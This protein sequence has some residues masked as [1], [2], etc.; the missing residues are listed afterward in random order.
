MRGDSVG[1]KR[2]PV[3]SVVLGEAEKRYVM[4]CLDTS[5]I[6][7]SGKYLS[8][9]QTRFAEFC[10]VR[11]AIGVANGT[12]AL[13]AALLAC[14]VGPGDEVIVPTLTYIATANA[15]RHCGA[16]PIFVD[17][18]PRTLNM[19][20][21]RIAERVT[22]RTKGI[23]AVHLYGHPAD[24]DAINAIA[25]SFG[26]FVIED[27]AEA[28]GALYKGRKVGSLSEMATFSFYGNKIVTTGEGGMIVSND[29]E[30][31]ARAR[32]YQGQGVDPRR[33]YW[34]LV[35]GYNFRMTNIQAAIGLG[36]MER[37][38]Q[39]RESR[40]LLAKWYRHHLAALAGSVTLLSTEAWATPAFWMQTVLLEGVSEAER[41]AVILTLDQLGVEARPTFYP[42]HMLPPYPNE[43]ASLYPVANEYYGRGISLPTHTLLDESDVRRICQA[44]AQALDVVTGSSLA[45]GL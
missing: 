7:S 42:I 6:S 45:M 15:V 26:L 1:M 5:W 38:D 16:T 9:F 8:D 25:K 39:I 34:H 30:L 35:V 31:T 44:L 27:A 36:Q 12:V 29:E 23:I 13:H 40:E 19:D 28:H 3:A 21:S 10:D 4:D 41:D 18:E 22:S 32:L 33:R 17:S 24:M 14:G 37:F 2:I 11:H 20:P 43:D